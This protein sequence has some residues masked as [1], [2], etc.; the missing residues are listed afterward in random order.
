M[1]SHP[2]SV[3]GTD[4]LIKR[5]QNGGQSPQQQRRK[6]ELLDEL[7]RRGTLSMR[8]VRTRPG[9]TYSNDTN[10]SALLRAEGLA[11]LFRI[12]GYGHPRYYLRITDYGYQKCR[13]AEE[14]R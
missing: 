11:E 12:P 5:L 7:Y 3:I 9:E 8:E 6:A 14:D 13:E 2:R 1:P 4:R 10:P